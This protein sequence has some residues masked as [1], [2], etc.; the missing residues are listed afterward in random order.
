MKKSNL[1]ALAAI[2]IVFVAVSA[3]AAIVGYGL[4]SRSDGV[5]AKK[6]FYLGVT[7]C[8]ESVDGACQLIDR[9]KIYT[10]LFLVQSNYLQSNLDELETICD[11]AVYSGLDIIVYSS[12]YQ[13]QKANLSVLLTDL[14][15]RW[16]SHFLGVYYNDEPG[17][18]MLEAQVEMGNITKY[19]GGGVKRI[20][21]NTDTYGSETSFSK[22]GTITVST[23]NRLQTETN[24]TDNSTT[25]IYFINGTIAYQTNNSTYIYTE[26]GPETSFQM[27]SL[28][29]QQDGTVQDKNGQAVTDQGNITRFAPYQ[30]LWDSRPLQTY[31]DAA[32]AYVNNLQDTVSWVHN[33]SSVMVFTSDYGLYWFDYKGGYDTVFAELGPTGN[34]EQEIAIVRGAANMQNKTWGT[35][36][37][38]PNST[39]PS[40][41]S[42]DEMYENLK[43]SYESGADY[44]VVFNY[45]PNSNGTG[46]LQDEHYT[47]IERFW[48]EVVKNPTTT[49]N[50]TIQDALVLPTNYGWGMRH[51]NDT[52]WGIWQPDNNSSQI[53]SAI[54]NTLENK[55]GKLDIVYDD[56][57]YLVEG[58]YP[59]IHYWNIT[60]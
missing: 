11:Y 49:N 21:S 57:L 32:V 46:L 25:T 55:A 23:Y 8:G 3:F 34:P 60:G 43:L 26:N 47:A 40:L 29:F 59:H 5:A 28:I 30:Q 6:P 19:E 10:N 52:I 50:I 58:K 13:I 33:Q 48:T 1:Y 39:T 36:L 14:Q 2:L 17:G 9:V 31:D 20:D 45:A 53:W 16:G 37:T 27:N 51:I 12:S 15:S 4:S 24:Y 42:G 54:Q 44:A 35:M 7:Y 38:W 41:L 56:P 18:K 22:S